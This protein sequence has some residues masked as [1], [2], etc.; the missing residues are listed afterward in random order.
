VLY[1]I[2]EE[3]IRNAYNTLVTLEIQIKVSWYTT[4]WQ[5]YRW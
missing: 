5:R 1:R 4:F 2:R 3:A